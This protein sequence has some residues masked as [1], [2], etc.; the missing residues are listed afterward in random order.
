[1]RWASKTDN[2][3]EGGMKSVQV[4]VSYVSRQVD[5]IVNENSLR[6][7]FSG[8]G[9]VVDVSIKQSSIARVSFVLFFVF[10]WK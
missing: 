2:K 4:H 10:F 5:L 6:T 9:E 7:L 8:F 3:E 1:M